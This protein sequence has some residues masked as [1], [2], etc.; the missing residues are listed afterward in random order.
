M[1]NDPGIT[2]FRHCSTKSVFCKRIPTT[3]P[4]CSLQIQD[5]IVDPF[6]IP[7]PFANAVHSPTTIVIRPS[8]GSF[9]DDYDTSHD[10][11]VGIVDSNGSVI[12]F[13]KNGVIMNDAR[14]IDC[15][16]VK[17]IPVAWTIRWDEMLRF[18]LR[19]VKWKSSNYDEIRM[20]CF[21]FVLEF[22]NNLGYADL[23]FTNKKDLC[24]RLILSKIQTAV[25]YNSLHRA[26]KDQEYFI[27]D[28]ITLSANNSICNR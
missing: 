20:N 10:L 26:L 23:R 28:C 21:N 17:V 12:E 24:E 27:S 2:C 3:C 7:Y 1:N 14:W 19:D 16:A 5:F 25:R 18:M 11:H 6:R 22:F 8:H 4:V 9:L 13:D 15:I